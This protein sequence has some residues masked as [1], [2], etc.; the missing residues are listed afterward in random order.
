VLAPHVRLRSDA[1]HESLSPEAT[2]GNAPDADRRAGLFKVP[3]V[4]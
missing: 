4:L 2:L 1:P 3:R